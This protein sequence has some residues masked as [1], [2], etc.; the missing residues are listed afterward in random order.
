M[1]FSQ[2]LQNSGVGLLGRGGDGDPQITDIVYDSRRVKPGAL[3]VAVPGLKSHGDGFIQQ[4][5]QAG[6]VAVVSENSHEELSVPWAMVSN[7]RAALG[8]LGHTLWKVDLSSLA[9][10]GITGTN[11]KTTTAF[12]YKKLFDAFLGEEWSWMFGTVEFRLGRESSQA[13]HTTPEALDIYR[14]IGTAS[15]KPKGLVMEVSSHSLILQ[16]VAGMKYDVAVWTNLTQDHLDFHGTMEDYYQAKKNLFSHYLKQGGAGVINID[17]HYGRRLYQELADEE[18]IVTYGRSEDAHVRISDYRCDWDGCTVELVIDGR[19]QRYSSILNGFFNI[20]NM[21]AMAAGAVA[22]KINPSVVQNAFSLIETV[23]GRMD[24]VQIDSPF[25]VIIDYAHT[26]DALINVLKTSRT[27]TQGKLISVFGCGGDRDRSK[28]PLMAQAVVNNCDEA[29]VTS[30]NPR[31]EKPETIIN[32]VLK[33]IPLD[34]PHTVI[35]DRFE[36]IRCALR[37]AREGDCIVIAGKG[38]ETYQEVNGVR[39]HFNDKEIVEQLYSEMEKE[40]R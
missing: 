32:D 22:L 36:A 2:L 26:P 31:S 30:D 12:L 27:L 29:V 20:Y 3:Y 33:G 25:T 21:T 13:T 7:V 28:R 14:M 18:T 9:T 11:G 37:S 24:K 19:T 23:P 1:N 5:L 34:F 38:H 4:A 40:S 39:H 15:R 17:D 6:A 16:R 10:V 8:I 35:V